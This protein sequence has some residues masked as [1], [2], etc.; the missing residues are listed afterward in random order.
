MGEEGG[1]RRRRRGGG[2]AAAPTREERAGAGEA[3]VS[4]GWQRGGG[5][6]QW[7][8][9]VITPN[10]EGKV[11]TRA[12]RS[13]EKLPLSGLRL[14]H[15]ICSFQTSKKAVRLGRLP[16][17]KLKS[18]T[19]LEEE[20]FV[21]HGLRKQGSERSEELCVLEV[22]CVLVKKLFVYWTGGRK[23]LFEIAVV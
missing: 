6:V 9:R 2:W 15:V 23:G 4:G 20:R 3:R 10:F 8:K 19:G 22:N 18:Q 5:F 12:V 11:G 17:P 13:R 16:A 14:S 1:R 7:K 21:R